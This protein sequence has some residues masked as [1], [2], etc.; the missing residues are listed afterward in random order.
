MPNLKQQAEDLGIKV[1]DRWSDATLQAKI[2]AAKKAKSGP[3]VVN[4]GSN[5]GPSKAAAAGEAV[6]DE[7]EKLKTEATPKATKAKVVLD[8]KTLL[9]AKALELNI[10]VDA[11]WDENRLQAEIQMAREGRADLQVKGAVPPAE[12]A[13]P[14]YDPATKGDKDVEILLTHDYW[15]TEGERAP[16]GSRVK[17]SRS[18]AQKLLDEGKAQRTDP[19]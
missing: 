18:K 4:A 17:L 15:P 1:D 5:P 12:Y 9:Q 16:A 6:S 7:G 8:N 2:D 14:D 19:L 13:D 11:D 3:E 10:E